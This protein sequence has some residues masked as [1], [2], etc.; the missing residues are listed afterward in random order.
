MDDPNDYQF[1][2]RLLDGMRA[3]RLLTDAFCEKI[4]LINAGTIALV[5]PGVLSQSHMLLRGRYLIFSGIVLL[6][7]AMIAFFVRNGVAVAL[8]RKF[9]LQ[10]YNVH[11]DDT[12]EGRMPKVRKA[13]ESG[14]A[15]IKTAYGHIDKIQRAG[16]VLTL[17]GIVCLLTAVGVVLFGA[18]IRVAPVVPSGSS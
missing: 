11:I 1:Y 9:V 5:L 18:A 8:D 16:E 17:L 10:E 4:A 7:A 12:L 14:F 2:V 15:D 6:L 13:V 3:S